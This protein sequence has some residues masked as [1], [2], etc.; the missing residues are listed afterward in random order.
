MPSS[1]FPHSTHRPHLCGRFLDRGAKQIG[2][3]VENYHKPVVDDAPARAGTDRFGGIPRGTT[4][5]QHI[6][7]IRNVRRVGGHHIY[8]HDMFQL[9]YG[10]PSVPEH[11]IPDP[12]FS[13]FHRKVFDHLR[14]AAAYYTAGGY[15]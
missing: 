2:W 3:L 11:G 13:E 1:R 14:I 6:E 7:H 5:E 15:A 8:H 4:P 12:E 10:D 9:G